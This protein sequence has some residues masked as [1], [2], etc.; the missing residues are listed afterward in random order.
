MM[1]ILGGGFK[2]LVKNV[3]VGTTWHVEVLVLGWVPREYTLE[4]SV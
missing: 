2:I 3:H 1:N 4:H